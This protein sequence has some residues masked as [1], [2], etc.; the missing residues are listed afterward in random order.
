MATGSPT[1]HTLPCARQGCAGSFIGWPLTS[2]ISQP[3]GRPP[4]VAGMSGGK[5]TGVVK[6][7][8]RGDALVL[9]DEPRSVGVADEIF[10]VDLEARIVGRR[11]AWGV[12]DRAV[13]VDQAAAA[14]A[15]QVMV[16]V[17]HP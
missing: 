9:D 17:T 16:I 5:Y 1:W 2:V 7:T 3:Q 14:A 11:E 13:D 15:N 6:L 8:K 10:L 12:A 4:T